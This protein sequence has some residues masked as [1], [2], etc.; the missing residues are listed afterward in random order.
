MV[1]V[2]RDRITQSQFGECNGG[3]LQRIDQIREAKS[4]GGGKEVSLR[5]CVSGG[6]ESGKDT[7]GILAEVFEKRYSGGGIS[8][9]K[10][11]LLF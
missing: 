4:P 11:L 9:G 1:G 5:Y 10:P 8:A 6:G 7:K 2:Q 3:K